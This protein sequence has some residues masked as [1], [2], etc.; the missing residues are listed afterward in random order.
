MRMS[1]GIG[2]V[3]AVVLSVSGCCC[4][5]TCAPLM[6][7]PVC[8]YPQP[9]CPQPCWSE[10]FH[11]ALCDL[12]Y[13]MNHHACHLQEQMS[14]SM[15]Q[16]AANLTPESSVQ[17]EN[18]Y[19]EV[20]PS[21]KVAPLSA[22]KQKSR[23]KGRVCERCQQSPCRCGYCE[24]CDGFEE[25]DPNAPV[26]AGGYPNQYYDVGAPPAINPGEPQNEP[27]Q[28]PPAPA[29]PTPIF[30]T[31][32][33]AAPVNP[34]PAPVV[35]PAEPATPPTGPV[36]P[37][38]TRATRPAAPSNAT[39]SNASSA[40]TTTTVSA[41][42]VKPKSTVTPIE[43]TLP[44]DE[45]LKLKPINFTTHAPLNKNDGWESATDETSAAK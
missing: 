21:V 40:R 10:H 8:C 22:S 39:P 6:C 24:G 28:V 37:T 36:T 23:R 13:C 11:D 45:D 31:P 41:R 33:S 1:C 42:S 3:L 35:P 34:P 15:E 27:H 7:A 12:S 25:I 14:C 26:D 20:S 18:D 29:G 17:G 2:M 5:M 16:L 9:C 19:T 30:K 4:P 44:A 43:V 32:P 38:T